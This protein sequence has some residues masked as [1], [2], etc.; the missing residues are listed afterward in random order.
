MSGSSVTNLSQIR[1]SSNYQDY[2][3]DYGRHHNPEVITRHRNSRSQKITGSDILVRF[4]TRVFD[5]LRVLS[6]VGAFVT[7]Q[8]EPEIFRTFLIFSKVS[9]KTGSVCNSN[10]TVLFRYNAHRRY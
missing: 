8:N 5:Q 4:P 3:S 10:G 9:P 1:G 2:G 7:E 6:G